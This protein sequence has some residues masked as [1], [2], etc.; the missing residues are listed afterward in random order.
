[1]ILPIEVTFR[2]MERN[3]QAEAWVRDAAAKLDQLYPKIM[4]CRVVIEVPHQRR[5]SG[6]PYQVR[7]DLSVP[8]KE[9]TVTRE[10]KVTGSP[11]RVRQTRRSKRLEIDAPY[12]DLH[13]AIRDA[14][15]AAKRQLRDYVR[16]QRREMKTH[17]TPPRARVSRLFPGEGYGFLTAP[18]GREIYFHR[19]SVLNGAFDRLEPGLEVNFAEEE[20]EKGPQ[21][22]TVKLTRRHQSPYTEKKSRRRTRPFA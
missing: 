15:K 18:D 4:S 2:E 8:G 22:S 5:E 20:G 7:V 6:N 19:D 9:L 11:R 3:D 1:M 17:D 14:F 16:L 21:A 12:K 13:A 10:P